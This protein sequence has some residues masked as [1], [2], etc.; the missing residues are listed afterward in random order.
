MD[1]YA[2]YEELKKNPA[3]LQ[4]KITEAV[5]TDH[6]DVL[7]D[8]LR[9][10]STYMKWG[11]VQVLAEQE[12]K[13]LKFHL[14]EEVMPVARAKAEKIILDS[15]QKATVQRTNDLAASDPN[16]TM[17]RNVLIEAQTLAAI[18]KKVCES[19]A[20][21]RDM[22][23]SLNSRQKI[24]LA[25]IPDESVPP[26]IW[27]STTVRSGEQ[28]VTHKQAKQERKPI[29]GTDPDEINH[30]VEGEVAKLAK[31]YRTLRRRKRE[32]K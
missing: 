12:A 21:K 29:G 7:Q 15:G 27:S 20:H 32:K 30:E 4:A 6:E 28:K 8:M 9:Q 19:L 24:E 16:Y 3:L 1:Y 17:T 13:K 14:D 5:K 31:N 10:A 25:A 22:L 26:I 2:L 18:L 23:Q 11:Y